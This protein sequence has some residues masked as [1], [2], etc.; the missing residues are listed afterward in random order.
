M[1]LIN[2][3]KIKIDQVNCNLVVKIEVKMETND[4]FLNKKRL[5]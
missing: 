4:L 2:G 5:C 1:S 3:P